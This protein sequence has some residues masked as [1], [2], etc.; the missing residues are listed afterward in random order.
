VVKAQDKKQEKEKTRK[1]KT[2]REV[3]LG[4]VYHPASP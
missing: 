1:T 3:A 4:R 2:R